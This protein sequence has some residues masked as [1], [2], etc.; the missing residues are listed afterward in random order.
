MTLTL[1]PMMAQWHACK[2]HAPH[3]ILLFRLGDFYEAFY[4]DA[5]LL[6]KELN[7]TLTKRQ[8]V[9]MAG[10]PFH[11]SEG[12]VD[13]LVAKG[14][15]VAIAE[16]M[17]DPKSVKG[18][19]KR[20]IVRVVTPGTAMS[21]ALLS[22]KSNTFLACVVQVGEIHGL[23]VLDLTTA[24]FRAMEFESS[25]ELT[26]ELCRLQ[27]KEILASE[28]WCKKQASLL[29][30]WR[31]QLKSAI[32]IREEGY[33]NPAHTSDL[34]LR[35]LRVLHLDGFGLKGMPAATYASGAILHYVSCELHLV[36]DHIQSITTEHA[37]HYMLLDRST[38]KNLELF[39]SLQDAG[40][41]HAL[42]SLLDQTQTPMGG[43]LLKSW[44]A[45]PLMQI[46]QI[47]R[48]QEGIAELL[49][50][51]QASDALDT[52]LGKI[53][54]LERLMM[55]IQTGYA[56]ARDL[57]ALRL[58]LE[59]IAPLSKLLQSMN[60]PLLIQASRDLCDVTHI[61]SKLQDA[62]LDAPALRPSSEGEV[63]C[64]GFNPQLD[65]LRAL[66]TDSHSWVARYQ[67]ALQEETQ[68][69]TLK[70]G[71]TRVFGYYIEISKGQVGKVPPTFQRQQTLVNA[72]RFITPELKTFEH[73]ILHAE[74]K[75]ATLQSTLFAALREEIAAHSESVRQIAD[76]VAQ[77][78]CL[79]SLAKVATKFNYT[80]PLIDGSDIFDV[81]QGRH[82]VVEAS[83]GCQEYVPNDVFLDKQRRLYLITGPNMAG[84]STFIRQ[85]ALLAIMAQMG[86]FVPAKE[87][88]IGII[89]KVF[90]RIGA[91]D[92]LSRGQ[93]TFMVEMT[94]TA[95]IL[96]NATNRS[97]VILD[98][99]GRGTS[100]YD[101]IS[102][103]WAVAEH[104]LTEPSK[105]PKTLFATHYWELTALEKQIQGAVNYNVA[106][107][108]SER[109]IVF[110]RKI[111]QGG[112]DKSYGIH[113][114]KLA[115]LPAAVLKRAEKMLQKLEKEAGK[116]E[117]RKEEQLLLFPPT[118]QDPKWLPIAA[119]LKQ[120][121]PNHLTPMQA[122]QKILEW[123]KSLL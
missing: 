14:Y 80:R 45:R 100:T 123:K 35:H 8:E 106:V 84:K 105:T 62:L 121:D 75:I 55:R 10:V 13:K 41:S 23:S 6:S 79:L 22:D 122:L 30:E 44:L 89:D 108:E 111:V 69:K 21:T 17:E 99:I 25:K 11:A 40:K 50:H 37:D 9:P 72:E 110:L 102:I 18:L 54:D 96:H 4:E 7:L 118:S 71:Y 109:G 107:H 64:K 70:V 101:G 90:S 38:Q 81:K 87:A 33:F 82:P 29:E 32:S 60:A 92:D 34:L 67:L 104:L 94:E 95:N 12:Y 66:Q 93:S 115:G 86:S 91:S 83:L 120:I 78:D 2:Q 85:V 19:V 36:V 28:K 52:Q 15:S 53:K 68:I 1:S 48:R 74:E 117:G 49:A 103:A 16:Q 46:E 76:A 42:L 51:P 3:A 88:H 65:E 43:R 47:H 77:I 112:T 24:D 57:V 20:Q 63:F 59:P 73:Q 58:S 5:A 61:V 119:D 26:D 116:A 31:G 114:A 113:V 27:P 39:E 98:E 97:L 56:T